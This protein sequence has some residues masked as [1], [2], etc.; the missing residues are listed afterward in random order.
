M[1]DLDELTTQASQPLARTHF[2]EAVTAYRA[3]ALRVWTTPAN[4][5]TES[6]FWGAEA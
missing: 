5:A 4:G 1:R 6:P 2:R 3:G